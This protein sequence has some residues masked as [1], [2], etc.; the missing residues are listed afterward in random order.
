M[1]TREDYKFY[2]KYSIFIERLKLRETRTGTNRRTEIL[3]SFRY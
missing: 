2:L 1:E 3:D